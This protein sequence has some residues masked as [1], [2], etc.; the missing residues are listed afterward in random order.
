MI[1]EIFVYGDSLQSYLIAIIVPDRELLEKLA[2]ECGIEGDFEDL[3]NNED[4]KAEIQKILNDTAKEAK[5]WGFEKIR[6]F[7]L[8]PMSF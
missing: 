3:C 7:H 4:F 8:H 5:L 1:S 2:S 6:K